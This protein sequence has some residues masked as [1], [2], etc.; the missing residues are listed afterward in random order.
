MKTAIISKETG[1]VLHIYDGAPYPPAQWI[2]RFSHLWAD[3]AKVE[4]LEIPD[5]P[6]EEGDYD[7]DGTIDPPVWIPNIPAM[8]ARRLAEFERGGFSRVAAVHPPHHI[9]RLGLLPPGNSEAQAASALIESVK[10]AVN[11]AEDAIDLI[12]DAE[13]LAAFE[14]TWPE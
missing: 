7:L 5:R 11:D 3:P 4:H 1:E 9:S 10:R 13:Q 2:N 6:G 14:P 12:T 8:R